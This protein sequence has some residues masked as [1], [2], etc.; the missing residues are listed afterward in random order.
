ELKKLRP[1]EIY[2]SDVIGAYVGT[3][4]IGM[5][6][7]GALLK[8]P[9]THP[10]YDVLQEIAKLPAEEFIETAKMQAYAGKEN[11]VGQ[12]F[13]G[14]VRWGTP[15]TDES[16]AITGYVTMALNH[17]HIME[18]VDYVTPMKERYTELPS[19]FEGNYAFIWDY[20]CRSI[21]HPRH[22]SIVGYNPLTGEPQVPWLEGTPAFERDY[23]NGGFLRDTAGKTIPIIED[24]VHIPARDTPFYFWYTGGGA[25]WLAANPSWNKLSGVAAGV[26]WGEFLEKYGEDREILPQ[27]GERILKAPNANPVMDS[28]GNYIR[29]YQSRVKSPA[30]ALTKAG[31]VGLDGRYLNNAPQCTGWMDLTE[32]GG[33]GSFYILWSG[34]YKP[35]TASAITYYTGKYAPEKQNGSKRG[36]AFVTIGAGI[37]D[38]TAPARDMREKLTDAVD[39]S[40][41]ANL[42]K[43][44]FTTAFLIMIVVLIAI[45]LASYL[46]GIIKWMLNGISNFRKG[47]RQFR[48]NSEAKDEFGMLADSFDEMADSIVKSVNEPLSI[49]DMDCKIVYMNEQALSITNKS[50]DEVIG[51]SYENISIYPTG[52]EFCPIT[53]LHENREAEVLYKEESG[54]YY[55][56][57]ANYLLDKD[58]SRIGYII[59]TTN[60]TEIEEARKRA[61]HA[62]RAKSNF[63]ASMSHEIR[64][65]MNAIIGMTDLA[66]RE[67]FSATAREHILTIKQA[68]SNL[69]SIINDILDFSKIES[70]RLEVVPSN[71]SFSSLLND[72]ISVIRAKIIDTDLQFVTNVDS[73]I[74]NALY[75]DE[76]RIR[77]I[78]LN[79]LS[80]AV[81]YTKKGFVSLT[82]TGEVIDEKTVDLTISIEDSGKGI[83]QEDMGKLFTE[84]TQFS[85]VEN[86]GI[87]GTGLGLAIT[88]SLIKTMNGSISARSEYGKGSTFTV[89]LPQKIRKRVKMAS[90]KNPNRLNVLIYERRKQYADS[91]IYALS[92]LGVSN[93]H[94]LTASG[95]LEKMMENVYTF[96]F[97]ESALLENALKISS[98]LKSE[99]RI[100]L[101]TEF[102]ETIA[103]ENYSV[104]TMPVHSLSIANFLNGVTDNIFKN[105]NAEPVIKFTAATAHVLIV[106]DINTN[107]KVAEGLLQPYNMQIMTCTSG[108]E[109]IEMMKLHR[110]DLV[111]MDHMMPEMDGIETTLR[112]RGLDDNDPYYKIVPIVALTANAV[113][114]TKEMFLK[115]GFDDFLSKPIDIAKMNGVLEKWILKEKQEKTEE[116]NGAVAVKKK[117]VNVNVEISGIDVNKGISMTGGTMKNYL[118][119]L[120]IFYSDGLEKIEEIKACIATNNLPLFSTHVH[121]LK[122]ASASIGAGKLSEFAKALESAGKN[123]DTAFIE[124][125]NDKFLDDLKTLLHNIKHVISDNSLTKKDEE[126]SLSPELIQEKLSSLK[127]AL[128]DMN[129]TAADEI[130][131]ALSGKF[132]NSAAK[133]AFTQIEQDILLCD[134]NVAIN[135]IDTLIGWL[136]V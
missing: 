43:L 84:F 129:I 124:N 94:I 113:S 59:A 38:F 24:G 11:P 52:S 7:P 81:K 107:L 119:T 45:L 49:V 99:A 76:V 50:S 115:N 14:I 60:V 10:N 64:T 6:T 57:S 63:L 93:S 106:D 53:A 101:L 27:F 58:G 131:N 32:N 70:G 48:F 26:S 123:E 65:P 16:G 15:V 20:K 110:F 120:S 44:V 40:L 67:D 117:E 74:P 136:K 89:I 66:L 108:A 22:H 127:T 75:G 46:T 78:M 28:A 100:V 91:V 68:S 42:L 97:V 92:N 19:A 87:E 130:V 83:K 73:N 88:R 133:E 69:L 3:N 114:G 37:E 85:L 71:Y 104:L 109:A 118:K 135:N 4:F 61:E 35:T 18:F 47:E 125:N 112:I 2:I 23:V 126:E 36:F 122:S 95:F 103:D 21:C 111:F 41:S 77:Q 134:Y 34:L 5:Y 55:K 98:K 90:V 79:I 33:S 54:H 116:N 31:F 8:A 121:A 56:G 29:D 51:A 9:A 12:R 105:I 72:V 39:S 25:E 1:R 62:S 17:D 80:N 86:K 102:G 30:P 128:N 132:S 96:V 82:V 13:E